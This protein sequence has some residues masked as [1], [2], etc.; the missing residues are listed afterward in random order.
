M[1]DTNTDNR[2]RTLPWHADEM[3]YVDGWP[4]VY[5]MRR[6]DIEPLIRLP[7]GGSATPSELRALGREVLLPARWR[8]E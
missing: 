2:Q 5:T 7:G 4:R 3:I 1:I 8:F 6:S